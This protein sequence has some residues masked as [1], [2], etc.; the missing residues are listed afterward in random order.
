MQGL[1][2][3]LPGRGSNIVCVAVL[4]LG[5]AP[6][7]LDLVVPPWGIPAAILAIWFVLK[8][9]GQSLAVVGIIPPP[10]GWLHTFLLGIGG[11]FLIL[12]L[13]EFLYPPLLNLVG[14][15]G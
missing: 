15:P 2:Q 6:I 12:V 9:Q 5:Y 13:S 1:G 14:L 10:N 4:L 8:Q 7:L 11:A 3:E